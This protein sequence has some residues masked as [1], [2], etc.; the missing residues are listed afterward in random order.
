MKKQIEDYEQ[1][2]RSSDYNDLINLGESIDGSIQHVNATYVGGGVAEILQSMVPLMRDLGINC[3]WN[4]I[5]G[6]K[7][8]Y[9]VTKAFHNMLHDST[10]KPHTSYTE[11]FD[12]FNRCNEYNCDNMSMDYDYNFIHDPQPIGLIESELK[13]KVYPKCIWRCHIDI[14][15]P[16]PIIW[17]F[18]NNYLK[19]YDESI[20]S[21]QHF[22]PESNVPQHII[23]PSIDP[24]T[25]KN[26]E[27]SDSKIDKV[28]NKFGITRDKPTIVQVSRFDRLKDM[29]AT[30][31]AYQGVKKQIDCQLIIAGGV[32]SDD[33]EGMDVY[34][35]IKDRAG[36]DQ[37]VHLL[38]G[39][40]PFTEIEINALQSCADVVVQKS[41][42]EGFGLVVTEAMWK[43]KVVIGGN[44]GGIPAQITSNDTGFLANNI[45]ELASDIKYVFKNPDYA[46]EIGQR[47]H[48]Y[49]KENFLITRHIRD[50]LQLV[51]RKV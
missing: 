3:E 28:L 16:N 13:I 29:P 31:K 10:I 27:L 40:P 12:I 30:I 32:A 14:S 1:F 8:Y 38:L 15:N 23:R 36:N 20:Y 47:A 26:I 44:T 19:Y 33:P 17:S 6:Q 35:E 39:N 43:G 46:K 50:Y 22:A 11:M 25:D 18:L 48:E 21:M 42:K 45:T 51:S 34:N 7:D 4:V 37:D 9:D 5:K 41:T 49:V 24:L 2:M